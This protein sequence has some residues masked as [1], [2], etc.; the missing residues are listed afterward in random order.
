MECPRQTGPLSAFLKR[1]E[2]FRATWGELL[3]A[4]CY[5]YGTC[6]CYRPGFLYRTVSMYVHLKNKENFPYFQFF[7]KIGMVLYIYL[8]HK[9]NFQNT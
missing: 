7:K 5:K 3:L 2:Y 1:V 9:K 8:K 4:S 6:K